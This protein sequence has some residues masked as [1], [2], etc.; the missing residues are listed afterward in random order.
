MIIGVKYRTPPGPIF[1][2]QFLHV[3]K[4]VSALTKVALEIV[5]FVDAY[6]YIH[7]DCL[8]FEVG[9]LFAT[10]LLHYVRSY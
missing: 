3:K 6:I 8:K 5:H 2:T 1:T 10:E 7:R 9:T 4:V